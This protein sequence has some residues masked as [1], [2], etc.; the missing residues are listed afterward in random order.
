MA[1]QLY[2]SDDLQDHV[3]SLGGLGP[4]AHSVSGHVMHT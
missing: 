3:L 2:Y 1:E 4:D